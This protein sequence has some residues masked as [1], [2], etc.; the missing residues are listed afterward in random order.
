MTI[1]LCGKMADDSERP[2]GEPL[3]EPSLPTN[4]PEKE[5]TKKMEDVTLSEEKGNIRYQ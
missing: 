4:D 3:A 2:L 1:E 5:I